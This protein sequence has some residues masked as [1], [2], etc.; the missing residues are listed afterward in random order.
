MCRQLKLGT[1][2]R[3]LVSGGT[4]ELLPLLCVS[5]CEVS[6]QYLEAVFVSCVYL[7]LKLSMSPIM[8]GLKRVT[9]VKGKYITFL[10]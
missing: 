2:I 9:Y 4:R 1:T 3:A 6:I 7:N 5:V 8:N 10:E